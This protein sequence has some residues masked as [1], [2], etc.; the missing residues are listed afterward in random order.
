LEP[1]HRRATKM[2]QGMKPLSCKDRLKEL[3]LFS[4]EK[5]R[6]DSD[7]IAAFQYLKGGLEER[8]GQTL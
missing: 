7:L 8:G 4:Q 3:E 5:G 6:L 1:I 2:I